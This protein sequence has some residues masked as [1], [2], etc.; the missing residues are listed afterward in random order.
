MG[1]GFAPER[2]K[3]REAVPLIVKNGYMIDPAN[4]IDGIC[5]LLVI[6]DEIVEAGEVKIPEG[7]H[8][9]INAE[10]LLVLPG[11]I[12]M[13]LHLG[14][15]FEVDTQPFSCA[16][17]D[18]VTT[19]FSPGAGNTFMAPCLLGAEM[20]RGLPINAGVFLGAASVLGTM[21]N[22]GELI[23]LFNGRLSEKTAYEK[24]S[25]N[26]FTNRFAHLVIGVKDHMGHFL[27]S[28]EN[29]RKIA[30]ICKASNL[31]YMSH[32]QDPE[33]AWRMVELTEGVSPIHLTHMTAAG[34]GTHG[35]PE[36]C[37][38]AVIGLCQKSH[39]T[40]DFVTTMV[41]RGLGSREGLKMTK[42]TREICL[43]ALSE[44]TVDILVSDGQNQSVMKGF[45][46]TRDNIP[47]LLELAEEQV[48]TISE[49]VATMTV[50][51]VRLL[52]RISGR[53]WWQKK[54]GHLGP[55]AKANITIVDPDDRLATYTIV[56]GEIASFENRP[57]RTG[58]SAGRWVS[59]H[60]IEEELTIGR[61]GIY[62]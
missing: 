60:G 48:L 49:A 17:S 16:V 47:A 6:G 27:S 2:S 25:K 51:P 62:D 53:D 1:D 4:G 13:H 23:D 55:G 12:D 57:V 5:D 33:H 42:K 24:M 15:L 18:G 34:C 38:R 45:G 29:I 36:A 61:Q 43:E 35:D 32:T 19:A 30:R 28:G 44:G 21:L 50:N 10:G 7:A 54:L 20:D 26:G 8:N 41:R 39:V 58:A 3:T 56:N 52:G 46:D 9:L 59:M 40:G 22:E 37:M 11:L 31:M 14:D